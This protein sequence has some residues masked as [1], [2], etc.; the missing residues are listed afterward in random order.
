MGIFSSSYKTHVASVV[1]NLNGDDEKANYMKSTIMSLQ[2]GRNSHKR[3]LGEEISK[4]QLSGPSISQRSFFKWAENHYAIG[5]PDAR[6]N[7]QR[8]V[9][10]AI[11][12]AARDAI[13]G[14]VYVVEECYLAPADYSHYA[15]LIIIRNFP[16]KIGVPFT[17]SHQ[18]V[19]DFITA[20]NEL[21]IKF[22]DGFGIVQEFFY[23]GPP[24]DKTYLVTKYRLRDT[25]TNEVG[26]LQISLYET[27]HG[28]D[29]ILVKPTLDALDDA[30][31]FT[32]HEFFPFLPL[33]INNTFIDERDNTG[34]KIWEAEYASVKRAYK[35]VT[36]SE[37]D[38]LLTSIEDNPS[39][40]DID[41]TFMVFG[42]SFNTKDKVGKK[43]LYKFL[44]NIRIN[45]ESTTT[46]YNDWKFNRTTTLPE[47]TVVRVKSPD[48][49]IIKNYDMRIQWVHMDETVYQGV[50]KVGAK[51]GDLWFD[52]TTIPDVLI[53]HTYSG[54]VLFT[55]KIE[56]VEL[57][58]QTHP[59]HYSKLT[60]VGLSLKNFVYD[61]ASVD[62][63]AK[64]A[65]ADTDTSG[66]II[67]LHYPTL[68]SMSLKDANQLAVSNMYLIFN[69]YEVVET[70]WYAQGWFKFALVVVIVTVTV[71]TGGAGAATV[72]L[73][74]TNLAVG[75]ALGL[76]GLAAIIVG[77]VAN[78][79]AASL[80]LSLIQA[81]SIALFG[82]EFGALIGTIIG[83]IAMQTA[84]SFHTN[85]GINWGLMLRA[86]NLYKLSNVLGNAYANWVDIDTQSIYGSME[87]KE[88]EYETKMETIEELLSGLIGDYVFD[89]MAL[90]DSAESYDLQPESVDLFIKRTL[91]T[92]TDIAKL[93]VDMINDYSE[94]NLVLPKS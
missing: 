31:E 16:H 21:T 22:S 19:F 75:A 18:V 33:R 11:W 8:P 82:D 60:I 84:M 12:I 28:G 23:S 43:Y 30:T 54:T 9:D 14:K 90:T 49:S 4:A 86:E 48:S 25:T 93:S 7:K 71:L 81:G 5:V 27:H 80:L 1:Y 94:L 76:T 88:L 85:A 63:T 37:I 57:Y 61:N 91:L 66:L 70:P 79:L 20:V 62:I 45:Q 52:T 69:S 53:P 74:G 32:D 64:E 10:P 67:P 29:P 6:V 13:P 38:T 42:V 78:A 68:T 83:V 3:F 26:E 46:Q 35:K 40:D 41:F 39:I 15:E 77:A 56:T 87:G 55:D 47:V 24:V 36:G 2:L 89:P 44:S 72:G 50:G 59:T 58:W 92:G 51:T 17:V 73:L 34:T 65:L